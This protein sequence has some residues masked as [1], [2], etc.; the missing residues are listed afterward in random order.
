MRIVALSNAPGNCLACRTSGDQETRPVDSSAIAD[1]DPF[2]GLDVEVETVGD[3]GT[4]GAVFDRQVL[5]NESSA[6]RPIGRLG[7]R[8]SYCAE[9]VVGRISV[10]E[11]IHKDGIKWGMP[12]GE[13]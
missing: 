6:G 12:N 4:V 13:R 1:A 2:A 10:C 9:E 5:N 11:L 3:F 7:S 8:Q